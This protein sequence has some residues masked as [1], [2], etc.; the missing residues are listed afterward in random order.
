MQ[1]DRS[2]E[3]ILIGTWNCVS[4]YDSNKDELDLP[5][6]DEEFIIEFTNSTLIYRDEDVEKADTSLYKWNNTLDSIS[7]EVIGS[8]F[9]EKLDQ[10]SLIVDW[11]NLRLTFV[12]SK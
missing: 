3:E 5:E 11:K 10:D 4:S 12:K 7:V 2:R 1:Q 6:G 8:V 9:I